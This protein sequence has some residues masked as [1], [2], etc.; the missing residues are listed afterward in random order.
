MPEYLTLFCIG[1]IAGL[2]PL[3]GCWS[4][5]VQYSI[6]RDGPQ[7]G[8]EQQKMP[9][10]IGYSQLFHDQC[11][12]TKYRRLF[13]RSRRRSDGDTA[14]RGR[15]QDPEEA[16]IERQVPTVGSRRREVQTECSM[17]ESSRRSAYAEQQEWWPRRMKTWI[18]LH[19]SAS[20]VR[21]EARR[22]HPSHRNPAL[23]RTGLAW[24][25][26][27]ELSSVTLMILRYLVSE[28]WHCEMWI[29]TCFSMNCREVGDAMRRTI[30][31]GVVR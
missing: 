30:V 24:C 6:R 3:V 21:W 11:G 28:A 13:V 29:C 17:A 23:L 16:T 22:T 4:T 14:K 7:D 10:N 27:D 2:P 15:L 20:K 25:T 12:G 19:P 18:Q 5:K 9:S 26:I 1:C 8:F 31:T